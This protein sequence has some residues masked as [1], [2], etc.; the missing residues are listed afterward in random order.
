MEN[1]FI[2]TLEWKN[3]D[4]YFPELTHEPIIYCTANKKI[5]TL[6]SVENHWDWLKKELV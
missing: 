6:K 5:G 3:A 4:V 1:K 2:L